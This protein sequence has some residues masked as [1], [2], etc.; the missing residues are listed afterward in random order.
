MVAEQLG[1]VSLEIGI[2]PK[3]GEVI[4]SRLDGPRRPIRSR[5][6]RHYYRFSSGLDTMAVEERH[7]MTERDRLPPGRR[8]K[9]T[10]SPPCMSVLCRSL[11]PR[12]LGIRNRG[13]GEESEASHL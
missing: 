8:E 3:N 11:R 5:L 6:L 1:R 7:P 2:D 9:L 4:R 12:R 10:T 13:R